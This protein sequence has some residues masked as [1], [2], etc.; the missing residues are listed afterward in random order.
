M[1]TETKIE[2]ACT[3]IYIFQVRL[4]DNSSWVSD[5]SGCLLSR[6]LGLC[7][8]FLFQGCQ[9]SKQPQNLEVILSFGARAVV[10]LVVCLFCGGVLFCFCFV[11]SG[12]FLLIFIVIVINT[13]VQI[14]KISFPLGKNQA[15]FLSIRKGLVS[16][17]HVFSLV[18]QSS[19]YID[20]I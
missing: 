19:T 15:C 7:S 20:I 13:I 3:L 12:W 5:I 11:V 18:L 10:C 14:T 17:I 8:G 6:G 1:E 4:R 2:T 16:L 9:Q